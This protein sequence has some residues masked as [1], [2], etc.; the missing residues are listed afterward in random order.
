MISFVGLALA[1]LGCAG[2]LRQRSPKVQPVGPSASAGDRRRQQANARGA[3]SHQQ[4]EE[5]DAATDIEAHPRAAAGRESSND[6]AGDIADE[7]KKTKRS[8]ASRGRS[9]HG[10]KGQ[11][12]KW[13]PLEEEDQDNSTQGQS[14][15]Q[16]MEQEQELST[17]KKKKKGKKAKD[18][19]QSTM[20]F[21]MD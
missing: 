14:L 9:L 6:E 5:S 18:K 7:L 4:N 20:T 21:D 17:T 13:A 16:D 2:A 8:S 19:L 10:Q 12:A 15:H 3:E 1:I 11:R